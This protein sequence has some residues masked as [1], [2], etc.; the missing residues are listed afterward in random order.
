MEPD[1]IDRVRA[2]PAAEGWAP[3]DGALLS[4]A[5]ELVAAARIQEDTYNRLAEDLDVRQLM[6][7]VFTVGVYEVFAMA[8]R[9]FDVELDE[10]LLP[11]T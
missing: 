5:D 4:A 9:T 6:D 1:E 3:L 7:V 8:M 11:Y 2:G 10:D